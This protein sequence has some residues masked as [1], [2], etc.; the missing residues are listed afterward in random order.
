VGG[1][2]AAGLAGVA[3][4]L[5]AGALAAGLAGVAGELVA[6]ATADPPNP[7]AA[8]ASRAPPPVFSRLS[9]SMSFLS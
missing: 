6:L 5:A 9:F 1:A 2:V 7:R 4:A 3:V 8:R